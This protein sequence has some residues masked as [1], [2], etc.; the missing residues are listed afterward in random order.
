MKDIGGAFGVAAG[1][2]FGLG[3]T[4]ANLAGAIE[5]ETFEI[6]QMYP[7]YLA[8]AKLQEESAAVASMEFAVAAENIHAAMY[9]KAKEAVD[10]GKDVELGP[11]QICSVCGHTIEG[12]VPQ[13]C[14][15]CQAAAAKFVTFAS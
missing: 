6:E 4:S 8:V 1:G 13:K 11:V 14:P 10:G 3:G 2:G 7:A 15:I 12:D 5:G 9:T